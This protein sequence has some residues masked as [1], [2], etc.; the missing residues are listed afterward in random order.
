MIKCKHGNFKYGQC[1]ECFARTT[2]RVP[3][4]LNTPA[5]GGEPEVLCWVVTDMNGDFYFA[6]NRQTPADTPLIDRAH[7]A[8]LQA[9]I[10]RWKSIS[11]VQEDRIDAAL[12]LAK[13]RRE[14][15]D[16]LKARNAELER[17][18]LDA[19]RED[20]SIFVQRAE[21]LLLSKPAGSE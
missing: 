2:P 14:E 6:A 3:A 18:L 8:P 19:G 12:E 9:E 17:L 7:L 15:R 1:E 16:Q 4:P 21:Q 20:W 5:L 11:A 10:G 13:E